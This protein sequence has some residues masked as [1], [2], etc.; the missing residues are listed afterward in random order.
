MYS[1]IKCGIL[2]DLNWVCTGSSGISVQIFRVY[3]EYGSNKLY[4]T[5]DDGEK[6]DDDG[7]VLHL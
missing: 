6:H 2:Q 3:T 1:L 4:H 5:N 7:S